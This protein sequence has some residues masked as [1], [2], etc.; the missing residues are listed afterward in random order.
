MRALAEFRPPPPPIACGPISVL[1]SQHEVRKT[2]NV[3]V[4]IQ[5]TVQWCRVRRPEQVVLA[6][7]TGLPSWVG[8]QAINRGWP[9]RVIACHD[10]LERTADDILPILLELWLAASERLVVGSPVERD[11]LV[12]AAAPELDIATIATTV[13]RSNHNHNH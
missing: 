3:G 10:T 8:H 13:L 4:A 1:Q 7:R 9:I 5:A 6:L 12:R 2:V 11:S